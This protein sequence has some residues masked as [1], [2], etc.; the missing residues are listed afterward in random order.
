MD[1]L[2]K[3]LPGVAH[4]HNLHPL[5]IHFPIA[6]SFGAALLYGLCWIW[7][8]D[9]RA[10]AAYW[11]MLL[12]FWSYY[13]T[14]LTGIAA[15]VGVSLSSSVKQHLL[16]PHLMWMMVACLLV[17]CLTAWAI[18]DKPFPRAGRSAFLL[19]QLI[20]LLVMARGADYGSRLVY[21]YNAAGNA[22]RAPLHFTK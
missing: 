15:L 10:W 22:V 16:Y 5:F 12:G 1:F 7:P 11:V 21:D 4:I 19:L 20:L 6:F 9:A 13:L 18:T 8:N 3:F 14:V 17:T 2:G